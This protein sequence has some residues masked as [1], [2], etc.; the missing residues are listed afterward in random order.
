MEPTQKIKL[1]GNR[2]FSSNFDMTLNFTKQNYVKILKGIAILIPAL[3]IIAF[4]TPDTNFSTMGVSDYSDLMDSYAAMFTMG[5]ITVYFLSVMITYCIFL[6]VISYMAL[7][8]KSPDGSV[9]NSDVWSKLAN[10]FLPLIGGGI[11]FGLLSTIGFILCIIPGIIIYVYLGFYAYV[12]INEDKGVINSFYRSYEI[13]SNN[14]WIT[15]GY[16]LV[17]LILISVGSAIF[18]IPTYLILLGHGLQID[19]LTSDVFAY[20]ANFIASVGQLLLYPILYIAMGVMYY[21]HRNKIERV[22]METEIDSIG[23]SSQESNNQL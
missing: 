3:L 6:Y 23:V 19:F 12:Y 13:V 4:F 11:I 2:D 15:L 18:T 14:W 17:F 22:D 16:G 8:V 9:K 1:F 7:Y 21:S 20:L 10:S 5:A